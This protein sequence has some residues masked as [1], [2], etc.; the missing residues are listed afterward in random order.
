MLTRIANLLFAACGTAALVLLTF[1][2]NLGIVSYVLIAVMLIWCLGAIGLLFRKR[3]A[4]GCSMLGAC[5]V[6]GICLGF[7]VITIAN[8]VVHW[9]DVVIAGPYPGFFSLYLFGFCCLEISLCIWLVLGL[10]RIRRETKMFRSV[11]DA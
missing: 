10:M 3:F 6:L 7:W 5:T 9:R 2:R 8:V 4:W 1:A 11:P